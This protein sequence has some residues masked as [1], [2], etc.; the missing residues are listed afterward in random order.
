[1]ANENMRTSDAGLD[2]LRQRE[3]AVLRYYNDPAR[4]CSYGVGTLV[5]HGPCTDAELRRPV[6]V[7]EVNAQLASGVRVAEAAVR[8]RVHTAAL[9]QAQFDALVSF[10]FNTGAT[11]AAPTLDAANRAAGADVVQLMNSNVYVHPRDVN[12]LRLPA[13][14]LQGLANRRR[15]EAAPLVDLPLALPPLR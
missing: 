8:R 4:H 12:G 13:V 14:R 9:T 1:M 10:T 5:H 2:L 3:G 7:V 15:D 11:G 6:T